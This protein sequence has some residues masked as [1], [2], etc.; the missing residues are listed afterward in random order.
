MGGRV[1]A[2]FHPAMRNG[3]QQITS[4]AANE[5]ELSTGGVDDSWASLWISRVGPRRCSLSRWVAK[6]SPQVVLA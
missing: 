3:D 1:K 2:D 4:V 6:N 5:T